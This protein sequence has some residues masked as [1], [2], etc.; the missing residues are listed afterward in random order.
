LKVVCPRASKDS[1]AT[2]RA[3]FWRAGT[4]RR[5]HWQPL[6][7]SGTGYAALPIGGMGHAQERP[8]G[9]GGSRPFA[10]L[11]ELDACL[12]GATCCFQS[13]PRMEKSKVRDPDLGVS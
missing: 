4:A 10:T 11:P 1:P 12:G 8:G 7:R 6:M 13:G 9:A 5:G 2:C 3:S